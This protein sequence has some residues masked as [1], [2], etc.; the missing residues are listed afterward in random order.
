MRTVWRRISISF[1]LSR[2]SNGSPLEHS[3]SKGANGISKVLKEGRFHG[4][5]RR[6]IFRNVDGIILHRKLPQRK[7]IFT[8]LLIVMRLKQVYAPISVSFWRITRLMRYICK[9]SSRYHHRQNIIICLFIAISIASFAKIAIVFA[10][11][12][13]DKTDFGSIVPYYDT[14]DTTFASIKQN[15][16]IITASE[17]HSGDQDFFCIVIDKRQFFSGR[18]YPMRH[19]LFYK[20]SG[21]KLSLQY[22]YETMDQLSSLTQIDGG[23]LLS[24]WGG[25]HDYHSVIIADINKMPK[26][27]FMMASKVLPE[28]ADID[29][30]GVNEILIWSGAYADYTKT[31]INNNNE[32]SLKWQTASIYKW[33][34]ST[35]SL[36][37]SVPWSE[38]LDAI[39]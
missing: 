12:D 10:D 24:V 16:K 17:W 30:D 34:G 14:A 2:G 31:E 29:H 23:R 21:D 35:Y 7:T 33:N 38:R 13:D 3:N 11:S 22:S 37:K 25:T 32:N 8:V 6:G 19:L 36:V 9:M 4:I 28:I 1:V 20:K 18:Y 26:V 15:E 39:Q 27:V 5:F